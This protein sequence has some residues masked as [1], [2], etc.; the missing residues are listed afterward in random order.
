MSWKPNYH[1]TGCP[2]DA[3]IIGHQ[4]FSKNKI[5]GCVHVTDNESLSSC[6]RMVS[7]HEGTTKRFDRALFMAKTRCPSG[8]DALAICLM[9]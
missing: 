8:P 3:K 6:G 7:D 4:T 5:H 9:R 1:R 2:D